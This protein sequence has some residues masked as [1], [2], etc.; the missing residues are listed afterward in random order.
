MVTLTLSGASEILN[1]ISNGRLD[2]LLVRRLPTAF[3]GFSHLSGWLLE[4]FK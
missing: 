4:M 3:L 2:I 1:L